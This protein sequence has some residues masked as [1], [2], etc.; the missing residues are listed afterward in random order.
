MVRTT[1]VV[2]HAMPDPIIGSLFTGYG[3]LDI[4]V[5]AAY[6][7]QI[8]WYSEIESAACTVLKQ[9]YPEISNIGDITKVNW[10]DVSPVDILTGG[11]PCQ[12]FSN[13]G[14]RKGVND[15]RHLWP[16]VVD[17]ID[18][19]RPTLVVLEN[20]RGHLT[21]GFGDVL[22]D[23]YKL[24]YDV[25]WGV[26]R[27]SDAGAPHGRARLFIVAHSHDARRGEHCRTIPIKSQFA[28]A[29]YLSDIV[30]DSHSDGHGKQLHARGMEGME[31]KTTR[32]TSQLQRAWGEPDS[33][34]HWGNYAPAIEQWERITRPAPIPTIFTDRPRLNPGF[35]EWMMGLPQGHVTGH[36]LSP[37]QEL[38]MLGN[39]VCPQQATLALHMLSYSE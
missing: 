34:V 30:A 39:C 6:G 19:L 12:P 15:E 14:K 24:G 17:S 29:E 4:A 16:H 1:N 5:I 11:Y 20:V 25:K 27:A 13:A 38:K 10:G 9:D 31:K 32:N 22:S 18:A 36:G 2:A 21:L 28:S 33:R 7:G 8:A 35:V 26:V 37:A 23:L 3:G